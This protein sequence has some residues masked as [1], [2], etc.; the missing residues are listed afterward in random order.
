MHRGNDQ[1]LANWIFQTRSPRARSLERKTLLFSFDLVSHKI[2]LRHASHSVYYIIQ[3]ES[4]EV[5]QAIFSVTVL[6]IDKFSV[7]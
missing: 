4:N 5:L 2:W 6:V 7:F 1:I 3:S